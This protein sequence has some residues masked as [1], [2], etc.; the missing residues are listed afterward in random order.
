MKIGVMWKWLQLL[1]VVLVAFSVGAISQC[2]ADDDQV[3]MQLR[4]HSWSYTPQWTPGGRTLILGR[5]DRLYSLDTTTG[6]LAM[7][8]RPSRGTPELL[9]RDYSPRVSPDGTRIAYTTHRFITDGYYSYDIA[10]SNIDGD[11]S[12]Q[13]TPSTADDINPSWSPDGSRI[14][15]LSGR[16]WKASPS[17]PYHGRFNLFTVTDDG[18]NV[19]SV[20]PGI[21]LMEGLFVWSPD[22]EKLAF[23]GQIEHIE[24]SV[25]KFSLYIAAAD[26]S[27]IEIVWDGFF[28]G[29][30][31]PKSATFPLLAWSPDGSQIAI[32]IPAQA[33]YVIDATG[34]V[35]RKLAEVQ[36]QYGLFWTRIGREVLYFDYSAVWAVPI[37]GNSP[38]KRWETENP[39]DSLRFLRGTGSDL[40]L[41]MSPDGNRIAVYSAPKVNSATLGIIDL[42][43]SVTQ[44]IEASDWPDF[45][46]DFN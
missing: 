39:S 43:G 17:T 12:E 5:S 25:Y 13:L 40:R 15:F 24:R 37:D 7:I 31:K 42:D 27:G 14:A 32:S 44:L 16:D 46:P 9:E 22:G 3:E 29:S 23:I 45:N 2:R 8:S 1:V 41:S 35:P 30:I 4:N 6:E 26:G 18:S 33:I 36:V 34:S 38:Y 11:S 21:E 10:V 19:V 28:E 20:A